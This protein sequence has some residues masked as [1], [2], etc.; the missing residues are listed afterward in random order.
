MY[1]LVCAWVSK[2]VVVCVREC[3]CL[4]WM[5]VWVCVYNMYVCIYYVYGCTC[6]CMYTGVCSCE[7]M[8]W[9]ACCSIRTR[10]VRSGP[11]AGDSDSCSQ[12]TRH[13]SDSKTDPWDVP[14]I[15]TSWY[16]GDQTAIRFQNSLISCELLFIGLFQFQCFYLIVSYEYIYYSALF[17][18]RR[19]LLLYHDALILFYEY[20]VTLLPT[21]LSFCSVILS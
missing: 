16:S 10:L 20:I 21:L 6:V 13:T 1:V 18:S 17:C 3:M 15:R 2:C 9:V 7:L 12:M 11:I 8:G 4:L 19:Q 5:C 14:E